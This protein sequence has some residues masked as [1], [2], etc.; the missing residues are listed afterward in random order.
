[1]GLQERRSR[2]SPA[3]NTFV[4]FFDIFSLF[5]Q[6]LFFLFIFFIL[7]PLSPGGPLEPAYADPLHLLWILPFVP[8]YC[9]RTHCWE[10]VF[11]FS[12]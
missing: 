7:T 2:P 5:F 12:L 9:I 8:G 4:S 6:L 10:K 3:H 11:I 1:M